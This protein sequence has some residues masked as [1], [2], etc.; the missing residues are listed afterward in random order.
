MSS[1]C[2]VCVGLARGPGLAAGCWIFATLAYAS[3]SGIEE[4]VREGRSGRAT[5][6]AS[7]ARA[8]CHF[9]FH[10][11]GD[12]RGRMDGWPGRYIVFFFL[13]FFPSFFVPRDSCV[14]CVVGNALDDDEHRGPSPW[15]GGK[16]VR[17]VSNRH[18][19]S[20]PSCSSCSPSF[21]FFIFFL[22]PTFLLCLFDP[23]LVFLVCGHS[24]RHREYFTPIVM[25]R[26]YFRQQ[27]IA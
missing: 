16:A 3:S 5:V 2:R 18:V 7:R 20:S 23:C 8:R 4:E 13:F 25:D 11:E 12:P 27:A 26:D 10:G 22:L 17:E 14:P 24:G 21:F 15:R 9:H 1:S 19:V 6:D